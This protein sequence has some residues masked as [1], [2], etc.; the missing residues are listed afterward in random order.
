MM[1]WHFYYVFLIPLP[2]TSVTPSSIP[3]SLVH[4]PSCHP[5][6]RPLSSITLSSL[7]SISLSPNSLPLYS[8][9]LLSSQHLFIT[10][11]LP[12]ST[13]STLHSVPCDSVSHFLHSLY[14]PVCHPTPSLVVYKSFRLV[15]YP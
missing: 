1:P 13:L 6:S 4:L 5:H 15:V 2:A 14:Y 11:C 12:I 3:P 10:P 9:L 7:L 8:I